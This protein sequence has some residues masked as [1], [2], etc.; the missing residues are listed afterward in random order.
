MPKA[1]EMNSLACRNKDRHKDWNMRDLLKPR[2]QE[3]K[4]RLWH[5]IKKDTNR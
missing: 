5:A 4:R 1:R 3:I 2:Y